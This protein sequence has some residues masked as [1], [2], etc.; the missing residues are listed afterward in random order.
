MD[1]LGVAWVSL[2]DLSVS[3]S[4]CILTIFNTKQCMAV[5]GI[6]T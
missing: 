6:Q 1:R 3:I 4:V 5:V 2:S